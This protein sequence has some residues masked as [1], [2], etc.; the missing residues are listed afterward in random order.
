MTSVINYNLYLKTPLAVCMIDKLISHEN[1]IIKVVCLSVRYKRS[2][3]INI[4]LLTKLTFQWVELLSLPHP[5]LEK[6]KLIGTLVPMLLHY[7]R[8]QLKR[9][10]D[11]P[12]VTLTTAEK[13]IVK[14]CVRDCLK[15]ILCSLVSNPKC[16]MKPNL[17]TKEP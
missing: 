15:S 9:R 3:Q 11:S 2:E 8:T 10:S 17:K 13:T 16:H 12:W 6:K 1:Q 4:F 14:F 7:T 5:I